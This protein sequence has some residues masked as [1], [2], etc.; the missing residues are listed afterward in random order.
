MVV[1]KRGRILIMVVKSIVAALRCSGRKVKERREQ[2]GGAAVLSSTSTT[3]P[4]PSGYSSE[5]KLW[6]P[7]HSASKLL[8]FSD[9]S[10]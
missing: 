5:A 8:Y 10:S 1:P 3:P 2:I 7:T 9:W 6:V 4:V